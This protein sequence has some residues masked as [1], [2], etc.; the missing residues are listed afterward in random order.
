[1]GEKGVEIKFSNEDD[2]VGFVKLS[3]DNI[4]D[5]K[6]ARIDL[7]LLKE[8]IELAEEIGS[9]KDKDV[10]LVNAHSGRDCVDLYITKKNEK[11]SGVYVCGQTDVPEGFNRESGDD[12]NE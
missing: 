1:M 3:E 4:E 9:S 10:H 11:E 2:T 6:S 5:A 8:G 12:Q 7:E